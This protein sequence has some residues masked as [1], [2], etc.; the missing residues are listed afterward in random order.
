[1]FFDPLYFVFFIPGLL[2]GLWAQYRVK[3]TFKKYSKVPTLGGYSGADIA[4]KI[5]SANGIHDVTVEQVG[6][7]LSD[8]YDPISKSL[9]LSPDVYNGRTVSA[10]GVAA[11]EVGH[12]I[13]HAESYT[14]LTMRSKMVPVVQITS[15]AWFFALIGGIFLASSPLGQPLILL[16]IGMFSVMFFFQVV[17]LPVEFD[18]SKRALASIEQNGLV[19][20]SELAGARKVLNAAALTYVAA[21]VASFLTL[22]YYLMRF[23]LVGGDD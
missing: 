7:F 4:K 6:G 11:H 19:T 14:W 23:G 17:T 18:A 5:L 1:M 2:L 20:S 9:R 16:G 10:V 22:L 21:A 3:T 13:Q 15:K 8:H 12:A